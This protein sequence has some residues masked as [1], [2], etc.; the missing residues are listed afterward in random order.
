VY[1]IASK[2][3][4]PFTLS[5]L[6]VGITLVTMRCRRRERQ[7]GLTVALVGYVLLWLACFNPVSHALLSPLEDYAPPLAEA[8]REV[9]TM[10][11]LGAGGTHSLIRCGRA[12]QLYR[13]DVHKLVLVTGGRIDP[14]D[15]IEAEKMRD[16]L[17]LLGVPATAIVMEPESQSTFENAVRSAEILR[18][19]GIGKIVLVTDAAHMRR[20]TACF[21]KQGIEVV[22]GPCERITKVTPHG[23]DYYL[24]SALAARDADSA[25]REWIGMAWYRLRGRI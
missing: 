15:P 6:L 7:R 14:S 9:P 18:E 13:P 5:V 17:V 3:V 11:V 21:Q 16:W 12:A 2:L 23:P 8:P 1:N 4:Q 10:V 20:A 25:L 24:P 19:R 22:P